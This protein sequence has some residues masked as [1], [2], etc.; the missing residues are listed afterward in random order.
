MSEE[1]N[2]QLTAP[3][4]KRELLIPSKEQLAGIQSQIEIVLEEAKSTVIKCDD[5]FHKVEKIVANSAGYLKEVDAFIKPYKQAADAFK[6]E[7]LDLERALTNDA[8]EAKSIGSRKVGHFL[9]EMDAQ[10][11]KEAAA[12]RESARVEKEKQDLEEAEMVREQG[13]EEVAEAYLEEA[14]EQP[15]ITPKVESF[16]PVTRKGTGTRKTYSAKVVDP[17]KVPLRFRP[18]DQKMLDVEARTHGA[19]GT[20]DVEGVKLMC[21]V[22]G[23]VRGGK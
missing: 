5:T 19:K 20:F 22:T 1:Q 7:I 6:K 16:R 21:N 14:M 11:E 15:V 9:Q 23:V 8:K 13:G 10:R 4:N 3:P 18:I 17:K 2:T 12:A